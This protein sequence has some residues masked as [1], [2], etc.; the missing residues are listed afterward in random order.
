M[1]TLNDAEFDALGALGFTGHR[2]DRE[3]AWLQSLGATSDNLNDAW[4][5]YLDGQGFTGQITN[6]RYEWLGSLGYIGHLNQRLYDFWLDRI[7]LKTQPLAWL[8][9]STIQDTGG[10][11]T[12]W[13]NRSEASGGA[14]YNLTVIAG[15]NPLTLDSTKG[16]N[17]VR[18]PSSGSTF[19][20]A[21]Q[22][23]VAQPCSVFVVGKQDVLAATKGSDQYFMNG[24]DTTT[25]FRVLTSSANADFRATAGIS[26]PVSPE[27]TELRVMGAIVNGGASAFSVV[28]VNSSSGNIGADPFQYVTL[29]GTTAGG[30]Q[31]EGVIGEVLVYNVAL[32]LA[33]SVAVL[34]A[35]ENKWNG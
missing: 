34:S 10:T 9:S 25:S 30:L 32:S 13:N 24:R 17:V 1:T 21:A 29:F 5:E 2:N 31:L 14:A 28:G 7:L 19:K 15:T 33:D 4:A 22:Q 35:L 23:T 8:D 16:R 26:R 12:A 27:D 3:L 6:A 20:P 18:N 11:I